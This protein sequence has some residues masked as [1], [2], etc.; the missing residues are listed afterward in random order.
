M[1]QGQV[2]EGDHVENQEQVDA[3]YAGTE[4]VQLVLETHHSKHNAELS[5]LYNPIFINI[6]YKCNKNIIMFKS[7]LN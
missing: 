5:K 4:P 6:F 1:M 2:H 7:Y 3:K